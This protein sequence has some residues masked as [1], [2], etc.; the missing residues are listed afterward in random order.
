M[1]LHNYNI[2]QNVGDLIAEMLPFD[3]LTKPIVCIEYE[4]K[5]YQI[6]ITITGN[7]DEF[8]DEK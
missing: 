4:G 1:D 8:I 2:E 7:E 6:Q 3:N 5:E